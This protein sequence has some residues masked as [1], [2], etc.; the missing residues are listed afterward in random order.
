MTLIE[1]TDLLS[2]LQIVFKSVLDTV[3]A[4]LFIQGL[5]FQSP[6]SKTRIA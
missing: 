1:Y 5:C 2:Y 6:A 4:L 3:L